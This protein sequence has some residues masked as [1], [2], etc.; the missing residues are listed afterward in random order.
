MSVPQLFVTQKGQLAMQA[1]GIAGWTNPKLDL[2]KAPL[3][4]APDYH[5]LLADFVLAAYTGY[6]QQT[7]VFSTGYVNQAI[8]KSFAVTGL[9]KWPSATA[10]F[11]DELG[12][13]LQDGVTHDIW[14]WGTFGGPLG[15]QTPTDLIAFVLQV[16]D[17]LS[18]NIILVPP[19]A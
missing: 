17:D 2:V 7:P 16:Y 9:N 10:A 5:A 1:G 4:A 18:G 15:E 8:M 11:E 3:P 13:I 6:L 12:F 19:V 14:A